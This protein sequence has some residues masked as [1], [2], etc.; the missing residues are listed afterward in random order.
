[1]PRMWL[2]LSVIIFICFYTVAE[3]QQRNYDTIEINKWIDEGMKM[4][5]I[6]SDSALAIYKKVIQASEKLNY[7][8]GIA[9]GFHYAGIVYAETGIFDSAMR[10]Y[11]QAITFYAKTHDTAAVGRCYMNIANVYQYKG[12]Y[13]QAMPIYF[14]SAKLLEQAKDTARLSAAYSNLGNIFQY[15]AEYE[16]ASYYFGQAI[17]LA[18]LLKDSTRLGNALINMGA[19]YSTEKK[20]DS[21]SGYFRK[22]LDIAYQMNDP[23]M[24]RDALNDV[25]DTYFKLKMPDKGVAYIQKA[26]VYARQLGYPYDIAQI[27]TTLGKYAVDAHRPSEAY[28]YL[29]EAISIADT[30]HSNYLLA[31]AYKQ[32]SAADSSQ[33]N[34]KMAYHHYALFK[35]YDESVFSEDMAK[36]INEAE[37]KYQ[38]QK[39]QDS[40]LVLQKTA[41]VQ[42]LE[43]HRKKMANIGLISGCA[44]LLL[45]AGLVY[46]N[47]KNKNQLLKQSEILQRQTIA[48]L[49]KEK[50]LV[51]MQS[52]LK[53]QEEERERLA[54]DLHDGVG[55]LL[56]GVKLSLSTMKGNV[57]LSEGN[58]NAIEQILGQLDQSIT[59][60]RRVSHNM[61]P[62]SLIKFGLG[63]TI[64][65]YCAQINQSGMI[66]VNFQSY[67]LEQ[68]LDESTEIVVYRMIQELLN[69]ILKHAKADQVLVQMI[70]EKNRLDITVEDDG[71]GFDL[72]NASHL[73]GAG[74][75]NVRSRTEYLDGKLDIQSQPDEG[76]SVH[77][78]IP[79]S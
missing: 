57:F 66:K 2:M 43:L 38:V 65:N 5:S 47:F 7:T 78:E 10:Y 74:L 8:T 76:T 36:Q 71:K 54:K 58:A 9:K 68:R 59:E 69:N 45:L 22:G 49:Q 39:K 28:T 42:N 32:I 1:M 40:I 14:K 62:E 33:N 6:N 25:G 60:L 75:A 12:A 27:L 64:A 73:R 31:E 30:I 17:R 53:G 3:A 46:T 79:L 4:E 34:Y 48:E 52:V 37:S 44:L 26:L 23:Q 67:G 15:L 63:E 50:Q 18:G 11:N 13:S 56:S 72:N 77:I 29:T 24:I 41:R 16:K 21:A 61:M 35:Q 20:Y 19:L 70:R 51:A 55:G